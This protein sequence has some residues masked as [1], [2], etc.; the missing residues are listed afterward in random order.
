MSTQ[1]QL[2]VRAS[3][4]LFANGVMSH[5]GHANLS[6]RLD[7]S[8]MLL[9]IDGQ[10]RNL[11]QERLATVGL[12]GT[13]IAGELDPTNAEIIAMH[14][15]VYKVRPEVGGIIHT[16]SPHLLAFAMA[17]VALPCRYEALLRWGQATDVPVAPWAPRGSEKS[18][19]AIID[20]VKAHPDTQAVLLG[21]HG[22][23]VFGKDPL[24]AA[25]LLTVLEEAAE[26]EIAAT[27]LG[28]AQSLPASALEAIR[29][30][31]ARVR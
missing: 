16:H 5:T 8:Q 7:D 22:V 18:V 20:L 4:A 1:A 31:M 2:I 28:G 12:D 10:V 19:S 9:T 27:G 30:S 6:A 13:V 29:A 3:Q 26:A 24:A 25:Q 17:N 15:E 21:N 14:S 11:S 23:L